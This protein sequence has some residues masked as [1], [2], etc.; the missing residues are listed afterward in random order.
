MNALV[1]V[2][3]PWLSFLYRG[4]TRAAAACMLLQLS[5]VGWLPAV[6]W[7]RSAADR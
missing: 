2:F 3:F 5:I 7:A 1:T 6:L 4:Q